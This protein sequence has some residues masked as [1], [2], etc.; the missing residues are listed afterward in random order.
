MNI[1]QPMIPPNSPQKLGTFITPFKFF[2]AGSVAAS[3]NF[4]G[5]ILISMYLN[6][7]T[8]IVLAYCLGIVTAFT[9]NR[10][11]VFRHSANPLR[12]QMVWFFFINVLALAQTLA[13]TLLLADHV[14]P[15][16]DVYLYKNEIAHGI[17]IAVPMFSSFL[18]HRYLT[19][20]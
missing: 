15:Y 1:A 5:R 4:F 19:F 16:F 11:Y 17:G 10:R 18:G 12:V 7:P 9:L 20:R 13:V 14:L 3:V 2:V 8:A 6:F